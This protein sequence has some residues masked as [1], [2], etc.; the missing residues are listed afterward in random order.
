MGK[1]AKIG[2][3]IILTLLIT[4][5]V[6]L[7]RRM[8]TDDDQT[9]TAEAKE[10]GQAKA[11]GDKDS[12]AEGKAKSPTG[13]KPTV[14]AAKAGSG[15]AS[16]GS[17]DPLQGWNARST[18]N[19]TRQSATSGPTGPSQSMMANPARSPTANTYPLDGGTRQTTQSAP[20]QQTGIA[21]AADSAPYDPFR[22][23]TAS[24][25][26][27]QVGQPDDTVRLLTRP[28]APKR[29]TAPAGYPHAHRTAQTN[30]AAG[31]ASLPPGYAQTAAQRYPQTVRQEAPTRQIGIYGN[32]SNYTQR[33]SETAYRTENGEYK[34]R[35]NESYWTI[36]KKF[37]GTGAYFK[38]LA[39]HNRSRV[40]QDDRLDFDDVISVPGLEA[41]EKEYP[42]LCPKASR[43]ETL[44]NRASAVS[45]S[46]TYRGGRTYVVEE[47]DTLSDIARYE[48][49]KLSRWPEILE[50]NRD[51]VGDDPNYLTPGLELT[52]PDTGPAGA[53][54]ADTITRRPGDGTTFQR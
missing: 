38:A 30:H 15:K 51:V 35:P 49:G 52:L 26:T 50:L 9:A 5:G 14:L 21:T 18:G 44:R 37:Y 11:T 10:D 7:T 28:A 41:V 39:E 13:S 54:P 17:Y 31:K 6:V 48:L 24:A 27:A 23:G 40:A 2:L 42:G 12:A 1:E 25:G 43:R 22:R 29:Q 34:V 45:L 8:L 3:A 4:F 33:Y 36:S 46:G 19:A 32:G 53:G 47:G 16:A 20:A